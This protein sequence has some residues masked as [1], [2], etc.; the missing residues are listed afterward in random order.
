LVRQEAETSLKSGRRE[1]GIEQGRVLRWDFAIIKQIPEIL[2][3]KKILRRNTY[4]ADSS[5]STSRNTT[6]Q[7]DPWACWRNF[8]VGFILALAGPFLFWAE[9]GKEGREF[10]TEQK[11]FARIK[12]KYNPS[13]RPLGVRVRNNISVRTDIGSRRSIHRTMVSEGN[14][15]GKKLNE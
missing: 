1:F 7:I 6:I 15:E 13:H 5:T 12:Q 4:F 2:Y 14:R 10:G 11:S 3:R 9:V 8:G